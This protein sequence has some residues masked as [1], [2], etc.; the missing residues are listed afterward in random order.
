MDQIAEL[1]PPPPPL[2][3]GR[4]TKFTPEKI[5]QISN[6]VERGKSREEIAELVGVTVGTLQVSCS[7]LGIRLRRPRYD[8][9]TGFLRQGKA[10]SSNGASTPNPIGDHKAYV[11]V[12]PARNEKDFIELTIKSVVAQTV[13]PLMWVIVSDQSVDGTD[14]IVCSY[15]KRYPFIH[16]IRND[17]PS[18]RNTAAKVQAIRVGIKVLGQTEYAY[19]GNLDADVSFGETYF[20]T[21]LQ[22]FENDDA[23]GLIG[24]R[25]FQINDRG[26]TLE[27]NASTESV[28]GA[29]QFFRRECFDQIG[30]YQPIAG[31][32]EDGIAEI[33]ARYHGWKTRSFK[34]LPVLHHRGLGTVGRSIYEARFSNGLTEY[35]VGFSFTYH[36]IRAL[37][38]VFERPYLIGTILVL[39]GYMWGWLSRRPKVIPYALVRFVRREQM[40]KLFALLAGKWK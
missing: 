28:A 32:M 18:H 38:R 2:P 6:L 12:T 17:K 25:I 21:L 3:R 19:F 23:L 16:F 36:A 10:R 24:G 33:T 7:R 37:S 39:S 13:R 30:G 34:E 31:G 27:N 5:R 14:E 8:T 20:E 1:V 15:T 22:H 40:T 26:R 9:G 29:I 11:L 4:S 35:V